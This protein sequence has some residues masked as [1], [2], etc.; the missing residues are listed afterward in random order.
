MYVQHWETHAIA[1]TYIAALANVKHPRCVR[2]VTEDRDFAAA[3]WR[4]SH[5]V[6]AHLVAQR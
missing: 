3:R 1:K 5:L 2:S 4:S 6:T